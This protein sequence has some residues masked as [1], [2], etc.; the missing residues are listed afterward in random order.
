MSL[1]FLN[2]KSF[3]PTNKV[4]QKRLFIAEQK[5][6]AR[7]KL[8]SDRAKEHQ[9]EQEYIKN[10]A[11]IT[12]S[13]LEGERSKVGFLYAPPPGAKIEKP[14]DNS[15]D[16]EDNKVQPKNY[17]DIPDVEK[18]PFLANA[19]VQ[20]QYTDAIKVTHKPFGIELR[21]VKCARCH[22]WGHQSGDREC[23]LKDLNPLDLKRQQLEDPLAIK[24]QQQQPQQQT[25]SNNK[26][27]QNSNNNVNNVNSNN[28]EYKQRFK[29][30]PQALSPT[31]S[32]SSY[33]QYV[34]DEDVYNK[35]KSNDIVDEEEEDDDEVERQFL[36]SLTKK[37]RKLLLRQIKIEEKQRKKDEKKLEKKR[38]RESNNN[39][40]NSDSE[41]DESDSYSSSSSDSS[42]SDDSEYES[43]RS[44]KRKK[45][46][47]KDTYS[48][49]RKSSYD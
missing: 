17:K 20:G 21:N 27:K 16:N 48:K 22:Q 39:K 47:K 34:V 5:A 45:K 15:N 33:D 29:I 24:Q 36:A 8:E 12:G 6:Q 40:N 42:S 11:L 43:K 1:K 25:T 18:F 35:N 7:E 31:R 4:N 9:E 14:G 19:P 10:R 46:S 2:L 38:D 26:R 30:N 13:R 23:P 32:S 28:N 44:S 41:N 37:Q 49:R 3:H